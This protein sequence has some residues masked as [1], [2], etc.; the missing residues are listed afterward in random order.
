MERKIGEQRRQI[1]A[2]KFAL[3][4]SGRLNTAILASA[5][6]MIIATAARAS[7]DL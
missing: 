4:E 1:C 3:A 5:G 6:V 2:Q 7:S